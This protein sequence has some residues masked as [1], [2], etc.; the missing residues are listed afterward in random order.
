MTLLPPLKQFIS[1]KLLKLSNFKSP[2]TPSSA[3][4]PD[5][6]VH[7]PGEILERIGEKLRQLRE[8]QHL[9]IEDIAAR[10]Q[11]QVRIV[12]AIEEGHIEM[13]P[14]SVYVKGMVKRFGNSLGIDGSALAQE[15]PDWTRKDADF[16]QQSTFLQTTGVHAPVGARQ[17][18]GFSKS[19]SPVKPLPVYLGYTLAI[20]VAGAGI[21]HLIGNSSGA[22]H[23]SLDRATGSGPAPT[24]AKVIP[25][26]AVSPKSAP[27]PAVKIEIAAN[28]QTWAE[29]GIDGTT[30]FTGN[31]NVG[32][33]L[34]LLATK[35]VTINT[36]NAGGLLFS[37]DL[38][39]PKP[40]GKLGEKQHVTIKVGK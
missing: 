3:N 23:T 18:S 15:V 13:L 14:E 10:T 4:D 16:V 29:I 11:I 31:L 19:K 33:K 9:S 22:R 21:S 34:N 8:Q 32:T 36:N 38:Q 27:L 35:Q 2:S 25:A 39:P 6:L 20:V 12:R 28:S 7:P 30:R 5:L 1:V 24:V 37:R 17:S 40:L 26:V